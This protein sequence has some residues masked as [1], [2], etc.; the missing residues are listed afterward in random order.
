VKQRASEHDIQ[1]QILDWLQLK[2]VFAWRNNTGAMAGSHK[3]KRWFV[4]FGKKGSPDIF[5]VKDGQIFGIE[6]K[7]FGETLSDDQKSWGWEFRLAGGVY[8]V[9]Y[10]LSDVTRVLDA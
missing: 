8:I 10:E 2:H 4:R 6:V 5:A 3:G 1:K 7:K 9:A